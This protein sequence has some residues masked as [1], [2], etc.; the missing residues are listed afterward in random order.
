MGHGDPESSAHHGQ[1]DANALHAVPTCAGDPVL[2]CTRKRA[3]EDS[4]RGIGL[5]PRHTELALETAAPQFLDPGETLASG[6]HDVGF[7]GTDALGEVA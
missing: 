6:P 4:R 5:G 1:A 3:S 7:L 2:A